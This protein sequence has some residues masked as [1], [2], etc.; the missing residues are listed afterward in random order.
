VQGE[1]VVPAT[2]YLEDGLEAAAEALGD[3]AAI[4]LKRR[5]RKSVGAI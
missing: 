1:I 2:A 5:V 4:A 3:T